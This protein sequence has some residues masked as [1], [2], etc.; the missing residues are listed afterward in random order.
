MILV[1]NKSDLKK[2]RKVS[3]DVA[4]KLAESWRAEYIETSAI[5]ISNC[6]EPFDR[7]TKII[8]E[9]KYKMD[10]HAAACNVM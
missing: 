10:Y 4:K 9:K 5:T 3:F 1:G 2:E 6:R 8:H 7:L